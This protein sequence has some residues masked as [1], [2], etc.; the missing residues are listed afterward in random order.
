MA[1]TTST[2]S[3]TSAQDFID[4]TYADQGGTNY[5]IGVGI[6]T[7]DAVTVYLTNKTATGV[8]VNASAQFTGTVGL[9]IYPRP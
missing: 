7:S 4:V 8:R 5:G 9:V 3:F 2:A 6:E 1:I